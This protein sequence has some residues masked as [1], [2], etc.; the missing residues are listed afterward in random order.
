MIQGTIEIRDNVLDTCNATGGSCQELRRMVAIPYA[1][2]Y[3]VHLV[4]F[5]TTDCVDPET[6]SNLVPWREQQKVDCDT[7]KHT[8]VSQPLGMEGQ[9]GAGVALL[10]SIDW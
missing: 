4:L 8:S 7:G 2:W 6:L 5:S 3:A 1:T 10:G 9:S